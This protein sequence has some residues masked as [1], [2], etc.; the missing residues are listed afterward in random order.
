MREHSF[1]FNIF[2]G[3][4]FDLQKALTAIEN[5]DISIKLMTQDNQQEVTKLIEKLID[6]SIIFLQQLKL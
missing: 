1:S 5:P 4:L 3:N 2:N 6:Y